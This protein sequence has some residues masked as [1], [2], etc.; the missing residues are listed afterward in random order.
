VSTQAIQLSQEALQSLTLWTAVDI[1]HVKEMIAPQANEQEFRLLLY[2]ANKYELDPLLRQI[3]CVKYGDK[4][5]QI[6]AGRDGFLAI[7][8]R[9]GAFDGL[10]TTIRV[11]QVP[12]DV[13]YKDYG[14]TAHFTREYQF[15]AT[16]R[17][18]I[19]H[20]GHAVTVEVWEQEYSTGQNLW[21]SKPRT[22][23]TKVAECQAVRKA[24][25]ISG[26]YEPA[27]MGH[28]GAIEGTAV[29]IVETGAQAQSTSQKESGVQSPVAAAPRPAEAATAPHRGNQGPTATAQQDA[30]VTRDQLATLKGL[31]GAVG[32]SDDGKIAYLHKYHATQFSQLTEAE[33]A[34]CIADLQQEADRVQQPVAS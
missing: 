5:A 32:M 25:N 12:L 3:W 31:V 8:H 4:P 28:E 34:A 14:K 24:F 33:A 23:L 9:T 17:A 15:V 30:R 1:A 13:V 20:A 7:A 19:K 26:L 22:M 27:E 18:Y 11:E 6:F 16:A 29:E 2:M 10:E 21:T